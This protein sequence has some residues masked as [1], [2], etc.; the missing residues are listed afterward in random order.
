MNHVTFYYDRRFMWELEVATSE[1]L[2]SGQ[3]TVEVS[4]GVS[5]DRWMV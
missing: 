2:H 5:A 3:G 1:A 4:L